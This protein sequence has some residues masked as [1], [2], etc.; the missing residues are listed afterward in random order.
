[1]KDW[2]G[3]WIEGSNPTNKGQ[4]LEA[5]KVRPNFHA[6]FFDVDVNQTQ[7]ELKIVQYAE[8]LLDRN[9][10]TITSNINR[11]QKIKRPMIYNI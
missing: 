7:V 6:F 11:N 3:C 1:M 5:G 2:N 10:K 8:W 4:R 9:L